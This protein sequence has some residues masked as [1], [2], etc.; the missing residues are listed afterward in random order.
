MTGMTVHELTQDLDGGAVVH[1]TVASMV[2]GD[3]IHDVA[4]RAVSSLAE[5]VARLCQKAASGE[6]IDLK[7]QTTTGRI[8]RNSDWRPAHLHLI[9]ETFDNR[10]V[11]RYLDGDFGTAKPRLHRQID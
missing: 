8:W 6:A 2:R 4:C 3:G 1:Q 10:I 9:Y 11:D 7:R 5:E